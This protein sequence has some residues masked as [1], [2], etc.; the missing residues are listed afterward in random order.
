M[1]VSSFAET[2]PDHRA[3]RPPATLAVKCRIGI[4]LLLSAVMLGVG[5]V[6]MFVLAV[7]TLFQARRFYAE[8]M[9]RQLS[10]FALWLFGVRIVEH[11]DQPFPTRQTVYISN[12]TSSLDMFVI[13]AL[14]LPN[15]RYFLSGFL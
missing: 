10:R 11:R 4:A 2:H 1:S 9:A 6:A 3:S 12:H 14:G 13:I 7:L 8:V 15:S 5:S